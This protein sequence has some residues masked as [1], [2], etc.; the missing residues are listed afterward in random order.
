M[1]LSDKEGNDMTE[2]IVGIHMDDLLQIYNGRV[3]IKGTANMKNI[4][5]SSILPV[6]NNED[7][8]QLVQSQ[9]VINNL[10]FDLFNVQQQYWLK[11]TDQ[12]K[13]LIYEKWNIW[14]CIFHNIKKQNLIIFRLRN[15][16]FLLDQLSAIKPQYLC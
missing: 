16:L 1:K 10:P 11:N 13:S 3:S 7:S 15:V 12:V 14:K 4:L 5:L 6:T 9:I 2:Y 8:Q